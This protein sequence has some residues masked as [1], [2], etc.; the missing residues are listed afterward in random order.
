MTLTADKSS[1]LTDLPTTSSQSALEALLNGAATAEAKLD[2]LLGALKTTEQGDDEAFF[3]SWVLACVCELC[4]GHEELRE[5]VKDNEGCTLVMSVQ[6]N[7]HESIHVQ[8][9][10]MQL[11][12]R[13]SATGSIADAFGFDAVSKIHSAMEDC[14]EDS[15]GEFALT[16]NITA[17]PYIPCTI[18][19][20]TQCTIH[21]P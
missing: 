21:P 12:G 6:D 9:Q 15:F 16:G 1:G 11:I 17:R 10:V 4:T 13:L 8:W 18:H 19:T 2:I 14:D 7:F 5:Y 3:L 20:A